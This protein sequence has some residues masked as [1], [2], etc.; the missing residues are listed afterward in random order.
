M[1][2]IEG[3]VRSYILGGIETNNLNGNFVIRR[4][5][6]NSFNRSAGQHSFHDSSLRLGRMLLARARL[7]RAL[8]VSRLRELNGEKSNVRWH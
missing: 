4:K 2:D 7:I 3:C 8:G 6:N 5:P 1:C